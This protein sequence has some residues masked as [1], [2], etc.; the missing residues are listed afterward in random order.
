MD[1]R[2]TTVV[3]LEGNSREGNL[4]RKMFTC[5]FLL[6]SSGVQVDK[7]SSRLF[8]GRSTDPPSNSHHHRADRG[9]RQPAEV[10]FWFGGGARH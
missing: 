3:V 2:T 7:Q 10:H 6:I 9:V 8:P 1:S 4:D 5:F